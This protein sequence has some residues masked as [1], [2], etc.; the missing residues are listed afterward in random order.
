MKVYRLRE[1]MQLTGFEKEQLNEHLTMLSR[2]LAKGVRHT[3]RDKVLLEDSALALLKRMA[4]LEAHGFPGDSKGPRM[5][6]TSSGVHGDA[7]ALWRELA[8]DLRFRG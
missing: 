1:L 2:I 7:G 8:K 6:A 5:Q 4:E 3:G